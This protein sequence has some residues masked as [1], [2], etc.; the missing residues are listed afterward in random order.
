MV[1]IAPSQLVLTCATPFDM[2][3]GKYKNIAQVGSMKTRNHGLTRAM[4]KLANA[5]L[6]NVV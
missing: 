5:K 4:M 1:L 6:P 3:I 2:A